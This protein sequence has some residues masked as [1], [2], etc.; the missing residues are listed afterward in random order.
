MKE[1]RGWYHGPD[2]KVTLTGRQR[3]ARF[4]RGSAPGTRSTFIE[5]E[6]ECSCGHVGWSNHI[7]LARMAGESRY[8]G[9]TLE[10]KVGR[11]D[12]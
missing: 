7:D 10:G 8:T 11:S 12:G 9:T 5:R 4:K 6:Y 1:R 3:K 2:S